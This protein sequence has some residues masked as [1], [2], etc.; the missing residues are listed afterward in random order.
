MKSNTSMN[1]RIAIQVWLKTRPARLLAFYPVFSRMTPFFN[2]LAS[3]ASRTEISF[4]L[5]A[6]RRK[7]YHVICGAKKKQSIRAG[8]N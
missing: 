4:F 3:Q 8:F 2:F 7:A 5:D 6:L 1:F